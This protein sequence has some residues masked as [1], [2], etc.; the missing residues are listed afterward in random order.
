MTFP[1]HIEQTHLSEDTISHKVQSENYL[2]RK[3][4][5]FVVR[6]FWNVLHDLGSP[7]FVS[8]LSC[9]SGTASRANMCANG[10]TSTSTLVEIMQHS[11]ETAHAMFAN[12]DSGRSTTHHF[13]ACQELCNHSNSMLGLMDSPCVTKFSSKLSGF[14]W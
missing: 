3:R 8:S 9:C 6:E 12:T 7:I 14:S 10:H 5:K 2:K 4:E 11:A 1:C 13:K